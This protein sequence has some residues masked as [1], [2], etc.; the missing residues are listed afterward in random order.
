[1]DFSKYIITAAKD[2]FADANAQRKWR[3]LLCVLLAL[4]LAQTGASLT[5]KVVGLTADFGEELTTRSSAVKKARVSRRSPTAVRGSVS[6]EELSLFGLADLAKLSSTAPAIDPN[7]VPE[8]TLA[9]VLKGIITMEP[10]Q[11]ALAV[12]S[13]KGKNEEEK[14]YG[15]GDTVPGNAVISEIYADRIILRRGG[16]FETLVM[17]QDEQAGLTRNDESELAVNADEAIVSL[18]D[19]VHWEV[20]NSYLTERLNDLPSLAREIGVEVYE[21]NNVQKGYRLISAR[22]SKLLRDLGLQPGDILHEVNGIKLDTIQGGLS[23]Y[24]RIRNADEIRLVITR[25]GRRETR[26]YDVNNGG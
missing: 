2:Y 12:I 4:L 25:N 22:G 3:I 16:V 6:A 21:E 14:L 24:E 20:D 11:R 15:V 9:L 10:M 7:A 23:A 19:G 5:W 1:M 8:T 18:G 17:E 13:E 26:I